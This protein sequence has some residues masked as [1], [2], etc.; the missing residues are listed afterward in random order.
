MAAEALGVASSVIAIVD[1]SVKIIHLVGR[2]MSGVRGAKDDMRNLVAEIT[3]CHTAADEMDKLLKDPRAQGLRS[4][5][6]LASMLDPARV[7]LKEL[8][9]KLEKSSDS[10]L[11]RLRWPQMKDSIE[12]TVKRW[13]VPE[14]GC[15]S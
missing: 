7:T 1:M 10:S 5:R 2:Y 15:Y 13:L 14:R 9:A 6:E 8:L 12:D 3:E 11:G 4:S